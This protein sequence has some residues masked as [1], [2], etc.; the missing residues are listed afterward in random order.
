MTHWLLDVDNI[1][2]FGK[3]ESGSSSDRNVYINTYQRGSN[4]SV[5]RTIPQPDWE[6]LKYGQSNSWHNGPAGFTTLYVNTHT[7]SIYTVFIFEYLCHCK[8]ID[9]T[10]SI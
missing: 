10:C 2:K 4:E 8:Y 3:H 5:W 7:Y 1:Y 9:H 6:S